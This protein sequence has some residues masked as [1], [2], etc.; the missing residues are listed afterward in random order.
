VT[1]PTTFYRLPNEPI[2][3]FTFHGSVNRA[4][5]TQTFAEGLPIVRAIVADGCDS[6]FS[7]LDMRESQTEF[8]ALLD[9]A[10]HIREMNLPV[11]GLKEYR[12]GFVGGAPHVKMFVNFAR[13]IGYGSDLIPIFTTLDDAIAATRISVA[14]YLGQHPPV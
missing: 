1:P 8:A 13:K 7:I 5:A 2:M 4:I 12:I 6:V 14:K 9:M 11:D 3:V 10:T